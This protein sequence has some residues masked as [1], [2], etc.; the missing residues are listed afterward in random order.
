VGPGEVFLGEDHTL[1]HFRELWTPGLLSWEGRKEWNA[2]GAET[3]RTK[4]RERVFDLWQTH[5]VPALPDDLLRAM[6]EIVQRRP[7]GTG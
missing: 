1:A 2:A 3:L 4:A 5:D 6:R 7:V